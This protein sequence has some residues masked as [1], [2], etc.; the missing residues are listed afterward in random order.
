MAE[1]RISV[2]RTFVPSA[3][4]AGQDVRELGFRIY[5]LFVDPS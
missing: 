3:I 1:L 4:G 2:D 5:H